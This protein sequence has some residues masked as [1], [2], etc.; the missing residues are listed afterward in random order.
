MT[1]FTLRELFLLVLAACCIFGA[2]G[3]I[4]RLRK[5]NQSLKAVIHSIPNK[6]DRL[7]DN[8]GYTIEAGYDSWEAH[9]DVSQSVDPSQ[10]EP[11]GP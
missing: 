3:E 9:I 1:R 7:H 6:L 10:L 8:V 4:Y 11:G 2:A 5:Q